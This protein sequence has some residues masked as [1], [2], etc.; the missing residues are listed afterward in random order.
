MEEE[1]IHG[2]EDFNEDLEEEDEVDEELAPKKKGKAAKKAPPKKTPVKKAPAKKTK[3][4]PKTKGTKANYSLEVT[5][6]FS[7]IKYFSLPR[8]MLKSQFK[9]QTRLRIS[10]RYK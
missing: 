1:E 7:L 9:F 2:G 10:Q 5:L 8:G 4:V 3:A 6:S